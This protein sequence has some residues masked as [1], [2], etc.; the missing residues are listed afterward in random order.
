MEPVHFLSA[1]ELKAV[2]HPLRQRILALMV[3]RGELSGREVLEL[4]PDAP[5]NPY[6]HLEV[7]CGA[8]LIRLVREEKRRGSSERYY[9]PVA[10]TYSMDPG[11]LVGGGS[12]GAGEVRAGVLSVA[13]NGAEAALD[14]LARA[15]EREPIGAEGD[16]P[17]VN[18]CTFRVHPGRADELRDRLKTWLEDM[19]EAAREGAELEDDECVDYTLYQLFFRGGEG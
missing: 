4:V 13:R 9:A 3:R 14:G 12:P 17:F 19:A 11:E 10:R 15:L 8:G 18:L 1:D 6:Y 2:S 16:V 5:K 7:L